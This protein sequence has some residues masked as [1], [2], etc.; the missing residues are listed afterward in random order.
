VA[1]KIEHTREA[2]LSFNED[3]ESDLEGIAFQ[4]E[5]IQPGAPEPSKTE[6]NLKNAL[7]FDDD[8][9]SGSDDDE[10]D[11]EA[12]GVDASFEKVDDLATDDSNPSNE[13]I[14][15]G[16]EGSVSDEELQPVDASPNIIDPSIEQ[17]R[18]DVLEFGDMDDLDSPVEA[19]PEDIQATISDKKISL[20]KNDEN[21]TNPI[22]SISHDQINDSPTTSSI[23]SR[24]GI[25]DENPTNPI[26]SI[27]HDQINDSPTTSSI[28][29]RQGILDKLSGNMEFIRVDGDQ[30]VVTP[31][32]LEN[33][34]QAKNAPCM[35]DS[36]TKHLVFQEGIS[37]AHQAIILK[38]YPK[39]KVIVANKQEWILIC[40]SVVKYLQEAKKNQKDTK[41]T[42]RS[43]TMKQNLL[44][45]KVLAKRKNEQ[46]EELVNV[47]KENLTKEII[48]DITIQDSIIQSERIKKQRAK[49]EEEFIR[50]KIDRLDQKENKRKLNN[51]EDAKK[52]QKKTSLKDK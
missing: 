29:S 24:Q 39:E 30:V 45:P 52:E 51:E 46:K 13:E 42:N 47:L 28:E 12:E 20:L 3:F 19:V 6:Q 5:E 43:H 22:G 50:D 49:Q 25:N 23:E 31:Y 27:S 32:T 17:K 15:P 4:E 2:V 1:G 14:T 10:V 34:S 35:R 21:P 7:G 37:A 26:G 8:D 18:M 16:A 40:N 36:K 41:I 44:V 11:G 33:S 38:A 48:N 9:D